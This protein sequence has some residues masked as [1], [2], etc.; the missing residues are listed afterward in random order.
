L[1]VRLLL[2]EDDQAIAKF[3]DEGMRQ[4]GFAVDR[5]DNGEDGLHLA[6]TVPYDVAVVDIMLPG[7]DGLAVIDEMRRKGVE[8]PVVILSAKRTVDDRIKGLRAGGDDYMTKPFSFL[9]LLTRIQVILKRRGGGPAVT[10]FRAGGL[11]MDLLTRRVSRE[12]IIIELQPREFSL[13][14]FMMRNEGQVLSKT[15]IM[16]HLWDYSFTPQ[17]NVV[18]V[19]VCR[20]RAKVD[21]GF[22]GKLIHTIRGVGYVLK[23]D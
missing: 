23:M 14:E 22:D 11:E 19:L 10:F 12:G 3:I 6:L 16:E 5:A 20:L 7:L 18:D 1:I 2:V 8:I 21:K 9:E 13:L 15:L 17:T 4:A